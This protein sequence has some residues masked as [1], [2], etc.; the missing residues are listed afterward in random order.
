[1]ADWKVPVSYNY[2]PSYHAY[3]YGL[4]YP[5]TPE[6]THANVNW[7]EAA[8]GASSVGVH[9]TPQP[10]PSQTPPGSPEYNNN[11]TS[12][13]HYPGSVG[14]YP[15]SKAHTQTGRVFFPNKRL[16]FDQTNKPQARASSDTPSDSE[17]HTPGGQLT[18]HFINFTTLDTMFSSNYRTDNL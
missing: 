3:A 9:Y 13:G 8:Y 10:P 18:V 14:Y 15:N 5:Q 1:M 4:R 6:Q 17:A 16:E 11:P 12:E 7:T 2:S